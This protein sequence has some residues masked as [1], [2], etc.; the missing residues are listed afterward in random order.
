LP[1][2]SRVP[3]FTVAV[4]KVSAARF[5]DGANIARLFGLSYVT[6]PTTASVGEKTVKLSATMVDESMDS[7]KVA[8]IVLLMA[9]PVALS[10]AMV[11]TTVG[12]EESSSR[13]GLAGCEQA[14]NIAEIPSTVA[15]RP[16][17]RKLRVFFM[18]CPSF[19]CVPKRRERRHLKPICP[20][21]M[22]SL[23]ST[24]ILYTI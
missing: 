12:F 16:S 10:A 5:A 9:T 7:S 23:I 20:A 1:A 2:R 14:R 13:S 11:E 3:V 21:H 18:S 17:E 8:E 19:V 22:S 15:S 6:L 4:Y 24:H